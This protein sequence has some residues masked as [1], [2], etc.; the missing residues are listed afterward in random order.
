MYVVDLREKGVIQKSLYVRG[1]SAWEVAVG[2]AKRFLSRK[3]G[4]VTEGTYVKVFSDLRSVT[5]WIPR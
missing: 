2:Q 5:V 3:W 1:A 4:V